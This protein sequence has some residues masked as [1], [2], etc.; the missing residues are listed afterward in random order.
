MAEA[1]AS[2]AKSPRTLRRW[3]RR[4]TG[5]ATFGFDGGA[6]LRAG[7]DRACG[8]ADGAEGADEAVRGNPHRVPPGWD[9]ALLAVHR[10]GAGRPLV[11]L[12][13]LFSSAE[14]NWVKY[15]HA[16]RLAM[17]VR[18]DHADLRGHG[19]SAAPHEAG[20]L[21]EGRCW[22]ATW[23]PWWPGWGWRTMTRRL[24]AGRADLGAGSGGGLAPARLVLGAW[25]WRADWLGRAQRLFIDVIDRFGGIAR[26]VA[27]PLWRRPS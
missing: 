19:E 1:D 12:H 3:R 4:G 5:G 15:G 20:G 14:V 27:R 2:M 10:M 9:G 18:G 6:L 23:R 17:A 13:G 8:L 26:E 11:M 21:P 25:G 16:A 7:P 24:F 22:R